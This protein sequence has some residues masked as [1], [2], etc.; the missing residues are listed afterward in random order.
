MNC[1]GRG[2]YKLMVGGAALLSVFSF[3]WGFYESTFSAGL[4]II[5]V[6]WYCWNITM[7]Q[8]ILRFHP[9]VRISYFAGNIILKPSLT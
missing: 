7:T 4:V 1:L 6:P 5:H 2:S 9:E 3:F 8:E